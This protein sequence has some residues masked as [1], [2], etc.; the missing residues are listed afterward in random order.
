MKSV[1][2]A[3][4]GLATIAAPVL[5]QDLTALPKCAVSDTITSHMV[6]TEY[7]KERFLM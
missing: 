3:L 6:S 2:I 5:A 4:F 7:I 1:T